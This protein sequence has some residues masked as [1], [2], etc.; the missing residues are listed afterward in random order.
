M[1]IQSREL[2]VIS[3]DA[4]DV[5][6][7]SMD[8]VLKMAERRNMDVDDFIK[9][10]RGVEC[11]FRADGGYGV[12]KVTAVQQ[13]GKTYDMILMGGDTKNLRRFL[14]EG[15]PSFH[16]FMESHPRHGEIGH[17]EDFNHEVFS[18]IS[19][20]YHEKLVSNPTNLQQ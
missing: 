1:G 20:E 5:V 2:G 6:C 11:D 17:G 16:E 18:E 7:F 12:D 19:K 4:G 9:R 3:V 8:E 10:H 15:E 14:L 13:D